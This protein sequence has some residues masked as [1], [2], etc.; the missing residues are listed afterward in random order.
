MCNYII[1]YL[2]HT[3]TLQIRNSNLCFNVSIL[4]W[5][6][7]KALP[8]LLILVERLSNNP[9][10]NSFYRLKQMEQNMRPRYFLKLLFLPAISLHVLHALYVLYDTD[11]NAL[12]WR[13][14]IGY[15]NAPPCDLFQTKARILLLLLLLSLSSTEASNLVKVGC[16]WISL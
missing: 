10:D 14:L 2:S 8:C 11:I 7:F 15:F 6:T 3:F 4:P 1:L 12:L 9:C 5:T 16:N 13:S